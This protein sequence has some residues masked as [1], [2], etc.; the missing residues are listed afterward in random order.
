[1]RRSRIRAAVNVAGQVRLRG[2]A[3]GKSRKR[4]LTLIAGKFGRA[5]HM[6]A[7]RRAALAALASA[8]AD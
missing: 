5:A 2:S 7:A 3:F 4:L 1:M 8:G 6:N